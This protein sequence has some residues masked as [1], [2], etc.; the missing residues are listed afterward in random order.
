MPRLDKKRQKEA[1]VRRLYEEGKTRREIAQIARISLRDIGPILQEA[2][3]EYGHSYSNSSRAYRMF[4]DGMT[5]LEVAL[6]LNIREPEA[7]E[8]H[9]EYERLAMQGEVLWLCRRDTDELKSIMEL[10]K[11]ILGSRMNVEYAL[12]LLHS[13]ANDLPTLE[14]RY[15]NLISMVNELESKKKDLENAINDKSSQILG[16]SD[17]SYNYRIS[18]QDEEE[19]LQCLVRE[20]SRLETA[21]KRFKG[22]HR[23][24]LYIR[25]WVQ[26]KLSDKRTVFRYALLALAETIRGDPAKYAPALF[27]DNV[28]ASSALV[29]MSNH[30]YGCFAYQENSPPTINYT[31]NEY[32]DML[33][34]AS[35]KLLKILIKECIDE[36][37]LGYLLSTSSL[38]PPSSFF[39]EHN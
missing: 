21:I 37:L 35:E 24:Y 26:D 25:K 16:L 36:I 13:A 3:L 6:A 30:Y 17:T 38:P 1:L 32:I 18:I 34:E 8:L 39:D 12:N 23:D 10:C 5:P 7:T 29:E 9:L 19:Q 31:K 15:R 27:H 22:N 20:K 14:R 33:L 28:A 11:K 2:G 4:K